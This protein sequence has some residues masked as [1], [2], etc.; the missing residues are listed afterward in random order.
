MKKIKS[1]V[2]AKVGSC[3]ICSDPCGDDLLKHLPVYIF[4]SEGIRVCYICLKAIMDYMRS[5]RCVA[6]RSYKQG[7]LSCKSKS[8]SNGNND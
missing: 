1:K 7:Y 8:D 2:H 4:G 3:D 5:M 6:G